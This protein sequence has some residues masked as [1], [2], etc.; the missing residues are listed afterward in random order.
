MAT[1]PDLMDTNAAASDKQ[2]REQLAEDASD[3]LKQLPAIL[4]GK[5]APPAANAAY[6]AVTRTWG[7]P[8][9]TRR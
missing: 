7:C 4:D 8:A 9:I 1:P 2:L 6:T 5:A 3:A